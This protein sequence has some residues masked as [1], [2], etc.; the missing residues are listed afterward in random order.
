MENTLNSNRNLSIDFL[1]G[2]AIFT[3]LCANV[4]GYVT[5]A[6]EHPLWIRFYGSIAA[7]LFITIAGYMVA[8][9]SANKKHNLNYFI[10]RGFY[11]LLTGVLMD[12]FIWRIY[13]FTTYDVLYLIGLSIPLVFL[14]QKL[15]INYKLLIIFGVILFSYIMR[16][17]FGYT[18]YPIEIDLVTGKRT[19]SP[20]NQ[21][22]IFQHFLIDGWFPILPWI[23]FSF[24]GSVIYELAIKYKN[25]TSNNSLI[26][27]TGLIILGL[28]WLYILPFSSLLVSRENYSEIF[29]P[30]TIPFILY[31]FG[32][33]LLLWG[34]VNRI[35]NFKLL[36]PISLLGETSLF[37]YILHSLI[38]KFIVM[39]LFVNQ[40]SDK[41]NGSF[42][43]S[44]V[45]YFLLYLVCLLSAVI[46]HFFKTKYKFKN[47]LLRFYLGS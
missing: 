32:I 4:I 7:P 22:S 38:I 19:L 15:K 42:I 2:I 9:T 37:I 14:F 17:Y 6:N 43:T 46:I 25:F 24:F 47:F 44:L 3:M 8:Y 13:P 26:I 31:T 41:V 40:D 11:I 28:I 5:P 10:I 30:P 12:I 45:V 1:R 35:N 34:L 23:A 39:P 27:S 21:T 36:K 16:K 33:I 18:D 20:E 29:Y